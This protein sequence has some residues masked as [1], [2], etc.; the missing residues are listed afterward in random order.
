MSEEI[1]SNEA[2]KE[3]GARS[4]RASV[5]C[6]RG[7]TILTQGRGKGHGGWEGGR[8]TIRVVLSITMVVL[9][10]S[11]HFQSLREKIVAQEYWVTRRD[12][13]GTG[14]GYLRPKFPRCVPAR[15]CEMRC[16]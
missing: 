4:P 16:R 6:W 12:R 14:L 9:S 1:M 11:P 2:G 15:V 13:G 10:S 8:Q 5:S 3:A 7:D